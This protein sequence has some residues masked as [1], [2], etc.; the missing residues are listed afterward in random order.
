[1]RKLALT[2]LV[3]LGIV[4]SSTVFASK[5]GDTKDVRV[6][7]V[8]S[9]KVEVTY[10]SKGECKVK[11]NIYDQEG[12]KVFTESISNPKSFKKAYDLS[13][14]PVGEYEFEIIDQEKVVTEKV[15]TSLKNDS[16]FLKASV[17]KE[18]GDKFSVKVIGEIIDPIAVN[19]Y[20]K[21]GALVYGDLIDIS[22]GFTRIYDLSKSFDK[23][24]TF[25]IVQN[26]E[27]LAKTS[28]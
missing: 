21:T 11:V 27:I 8:E 10:F 7:S 2:T 16:K 22:K 13:N 3:A 14:L 24:I 4:S 5:A 20:S 23:D 17:I 25:E 18:E 28:F 9:D 12:S 1:M 6:A 19:I 26:G 15:S